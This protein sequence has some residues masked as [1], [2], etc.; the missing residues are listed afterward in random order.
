MSE[1]EVTV[2]EVAEIRLAEDE[3][4]KVEVARHP[5]GLFSIVFGAGFVMVAVVVLWIVMLVSDL[6]FLPL[7]EGVKSLIS[8]IAVVLLVLTLVIAW[9]GVTIYRNNL[10]VVT[11]K[12]VI[13]QTSLS[14]FD[15]SVQTI[16]LASVED[17]SF[18]KR[19]ILQSLF[20]YGSLRLATVG[21]ETTYQFNFVHDPEGQVRAISEVVQGVKGEKH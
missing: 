16:D 10:F 13:Q 20:D 3:E 8:L 5:L 1:K 15:K 2:R 21:D 4:V 18:K 7:N 14:L 17:V 11:N 6:D 12:R 19:G 9:V